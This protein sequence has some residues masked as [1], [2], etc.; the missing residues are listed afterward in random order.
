[1]NPGKKL[2]ALFALLILSLFAVSCGDT[3]KA[4]KLIGEG[5]AAAIV[6]IC[7]RLDGLP[8]AIELAAARLK[9]L[10]PQM[11]LGRLDTRLALLT[12]GARDRPARQQTLRETIG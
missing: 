11:L 5:N 3:G 1:M 2:Y 12:G 4:N 6:G 8:L 10:S 9:V 7:H